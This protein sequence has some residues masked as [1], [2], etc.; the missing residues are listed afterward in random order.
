MVAK[1]L[2]ILF[3][4]HMCGLLNW[5]KCVNEYLIETKVSDVAPSQRGLNTIT[6]GY[7]RRQWLADLVSVL[8]T[9]FLL[10]CLVMWCTLQPKNCVI[11]A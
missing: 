10:F 11:S 6:L 3:L 7:K 9:L 5:C 8:T 2:F 4:L 1:T